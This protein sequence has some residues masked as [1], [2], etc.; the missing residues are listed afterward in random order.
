MT[1]QNK[2]HYHFIGI[3]GIG[4]SGLAL[5]LIKQG[6]SVS[7]SDLSQNKIINQLVNLGATIYQG[8]SEKWVKP[9]YQIVYS[10]SIKEN[11]P[12]FVAAKKFNCKIYHR[13]D[14]LASLIETKKTISVAGTHG[15]TTT[16]SL[17]AW[18]LKSA[19]YDPSY[20]IGGVINQTGANSD[21]GDG[22]YLI[23][24]ADESDGTFLKYASYGAITTNIGLDHMNYFRSE[25]N[26]IEHFDKFLKSIKNKQL[27]FWCKDDERLARLNSEGVSYGFSM[28]SDLKILSYRQ[29]NWSTFID[30]NFKNQCF[31]EIEINL[32]GR[33]NA[34]NTAAV[35]GICYNLGIAE[36][37]IRKAFK[38]FK[39]VK[40][41]VEIHGSH[42]EVLLLDDYA[43]HPTEIKTT[44]EGVRQAILD[45][46]LIV[47]FQPHRYSRIKDCLSC[48][49]EVFN[50]ADKII[51]TEIYSA[52]EEPL[53]GI[54]HDSIIQ[55][56]T[57]KKVEHV[58]RKD[59]SFHLKGL[60]KSNDVLLSLGAGD[61]TELSKELKNEWI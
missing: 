50:H 2:P 1:H 10:S 27:C 30:L 56:L 36:E 44:L 21:I 31:N 7:G 59:L 53:E 45:R 18:V 8:H 46:H 33:H 12:E 11:N 29:Q 52:G 9:H 58:K 55:Q 19:G 41:R 37:E 61:I 22:L 32:I 15:K 35:F 6:C 16:S 54:S 5:A 34:L 24:E 25:A 3:G 60:L 51:I 38:V 40:R 20:F 28:N 48:F 26:L 47:V 4:M 13:S 39:G 14:V 43:H 42:K 57:H 17:L 23:A 49:K